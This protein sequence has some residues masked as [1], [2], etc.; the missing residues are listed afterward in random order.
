MSSVSKSDNSKRKDEL[1]ETREQYQNKEVEAAK[2]KAKEIQALRKKHSEEVKALSDQFSRQIDEVRNRNQETISE[3]D[4]KNQEKVDSIR[5]IYLD[6]AKKQTEKSETE[7]REMRAAYEGQIEKDSRV[8]QQQKEI[9]KR[10]F[11]DSLQERDRVIEDTYKRNVDEMQSRLQD[12]NR[13]LRSKFEKETDLIRQSK[14]QEKL[15]SADQ[16][17]QLKSYNRNIISDMRRGHDYEKNRMEKNYMRDRAEEQRAYAQVLTEKDSDLRIQ[18]Q[19][20]AD[21][22]QRKLEA[23]KESLEQANADFREKITQRIDEEVRQG[24]L[25]AEELRK[26]R[27]SDLTADRRQR[28]IEKK[29]IQK[30]YEDRYQDLARQRD[31]IYEVVNEDAKKK[32]QK[33]H[34]D[35]QG[36]VSQHVNRLKTQANLDQ[37]RHR[38]EKLQMVHKYEGELDFTQTRADKRL[39][40][41]KKNEQDAQATQMQY[42][43]ANVA[44]L[45]ED[46]ATRLLEQRERHME[47]LREL[48]TRLDQRHRES[49][50]NLGRK[51][52]ETRSGY[53]EMLRVQ[54]EQH[55]EELLR[56]TRLNE[57]R[58]KER[59]K[60]VR[61][62][63]KSIENKYETR[64]SQQ[65][66]VHRADMERLEKRHQEQM[67]SVSNRMNALARKA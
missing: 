39:R 25:V 36:L 4:A 28:D 5:R 24:K 19:K 14:D 40:Q 2:R 20:V 64:L 52:E 26:N 38:E 35:S 21:D 33:V 8:H 66:A 12:Q 49:T 15:E 3:R 58:I 11:T 7:T 59:E 41:V 54:R 44:Q 17:D 46:F 60:S 22:L 61:T 9:M 27:Q 29:N 65:E 30:V 53:E 51:L 67:M 42:F 56:L 63:Q 57:Q 55:Q 16:L 47:E 43:Q 23:K 13:K 1:R 18:R 10:D 50:K 62:D 6:K 31:G 37:A 32:I 48:N 45:K 34:Q